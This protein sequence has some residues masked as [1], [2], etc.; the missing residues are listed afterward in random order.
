MLYL[1]MEYVEGKTLVE[2][3]KEKKVLPLAEAAD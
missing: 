3:L 2:V 1:V